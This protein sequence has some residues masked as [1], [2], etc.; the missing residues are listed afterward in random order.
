MGMVLAALALGAFQ[1]SALLE[2][3][4]AVRLRAGEQVRLYRRGGRTANGLYQALVVVAGDKVFVKT[5]TSAGSL[6]LTGEQ[7]SKLSVA[8]A[9]INLATLTSK[10]RDRPMWPSAYDAQDLSLA[11]RRGKDIFTWSN[12]AYEEPSDVPLLELLQEFESLALA[13][14]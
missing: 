4:E 6:K 13:K 10:K 9:P 12:E 14:R 5:H 3:N 7:K 1:L 2:P 11:A 8:L